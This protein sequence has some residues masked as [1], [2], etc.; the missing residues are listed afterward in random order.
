MDGTRLRHIVP[1]HSEILYTNK[2]HNVLDINQGVSEF[3]HQVKF[4]S[5]WIITNIVRIYHVSAIFAIYFHYVASGPMWRPHLAG[6]AEGIATWG[7]HRILDK[8]KQ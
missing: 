2:L 5:L 8:R 6:R 7:P 4:A 1:Y 3:G